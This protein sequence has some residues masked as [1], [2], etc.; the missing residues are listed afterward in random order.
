MQDREKN[1]YKFIGKVAL[2]FR[3]SL[4]NLC[5]LIG[6]E[7]NEENKKSIYEKIVEHAIG[8]NP[9]LQKQYNH[10][11]FY[12][13]LNEPSYV[14]DD[15]YSNALN[16]MKRYKKASS[17]GNKEER[18]K[19]LNELN[20]TENDFKDLIKRKKTKTLTQDEII[21][22][23]KYRIKTVLSKRKFY[24]VYGI[25]SRDNLMVREKE[26]ESDVLKYKINNINEYYHDIKLYPKSRGI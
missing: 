15:S 3:V 16:Y 6:K 26:L 22:I 7:V 9:P 5:K 4:D 13:T 24:E 23:T 14:S 25:I 10:L 21:V 18:H 17:S 20:K 11:F 8:Y 1:F 2:E 12:E 19:I